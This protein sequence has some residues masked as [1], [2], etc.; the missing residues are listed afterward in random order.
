[1][2]PD[3]KLF[4]LALNRVS[5]LKPKEK[6]LLAEI[7]SSLGWFLSLSRGDLEAILGRK[8]KSSR[9]QPAEYLELAQTD[10]NYLTAG[11]INCTFYWDKAFPPLLRE[12]YDPP[13]LLFYRGR[14]ADY[15]KPLVAVVG[16]RRPTGAAR[17][18]AYSLSLELAQAGIGTVSG[19]A[20]GIDS[21]AHRGSLDAGGTTVA[22]LGNGIDTLFPRSSSAVGRRILKQGGLI[23]S[24][25]P[26]GT[27]PAAYN[28]PARNRIIS[29][30]ART[31]VVVQAP[32]RSG[33]LITAEFA[34]QQ[35]RD[36]VVH[37]AGLSGQAS[38][39]AQ[40]LQLDGAPVVSR[41]LDILESWNWT[42]CKAGAGSAESVIADALAPGGGEG[43]KRLDT[44]ERLVR[45]MELELA[46]K[47][48]RHNGDFYIKEHS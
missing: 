10:Q 4:L 18:A 36:L 27:P 21:E 1:M 34:L 32:W 8:I 6:L 44:A 37:R 2:A 5:F 20:R 9:W 45:L 16:T 38:G 22:V 13:V 48:R 23:V 47:G 3:E 25:Y 24:E 17:S 11:P 15:T 39:G 46:Q 12:I 26:P 28:F 40:K 43:S 33:A 30:L 29:G 14:L 41:A 35:G 31:I 42:S 19:L 7:Y